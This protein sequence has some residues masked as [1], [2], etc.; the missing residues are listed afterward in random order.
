MLAALATTLIV[1]TEC[2]RT[3]RLMTF[4]QSCLSTEKYCFVSSVSE[5]GWTR[6][7]LPPGQQA[8]SHPQG[9]AHVH[10]CLY[11]SHKVRVKIFLDSK[12][13][14]GFKEERPNQSCKAENGSQGRQP[15]SLLP[16][17][18]KFLLQ[19]SNMFWLCCWMATLKALQHSAHLFGSAWSLE[20]TIRVIQGSVSF[21]PVGK[22]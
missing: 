1:R 7:K 11:A 20:N 10:C 13:I 18:Q 2:R 22:Q 4:L 9:P 8:K 12:D 19:S 16:A 21:L 3:P 15:F 5:F 6:I 17:N 14:E